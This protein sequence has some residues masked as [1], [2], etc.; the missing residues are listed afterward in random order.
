MAFRSG[1]VAVPPGTV[2]DLT[3]SY[4]RIRFPGVATRGVRGNFASVLPPGATIALLCT[5]PLAWAAEL[6]G[7]GQACR[8]RSWFTPPASMPVRSSPWRELGKDEVEQVLA[9]A[10][11]LSSRERVVAMSARFLGTPYRVSPLGEGAGKDPDPRFRLDAVD[12][13]TFVE[14]TLALSV[15]RQ[16]SQ[17]ER[18]LE[19]IRYADEVSYGGRNHL[20]E[21][22]W[23]PNNSRKGLIVDVTRQYGG[24]S[25]IRVEKKILPTTWLAPSARALDLPKDKQITGVFP[26]DVIPLDAVRDIAAQIPSGTIL[27]VV[28][29]ERPW[30]VT[31]ISHVGFIVQLDGKTFVRHATAGSRARV[32]DEPLP[33]FLAR[34]E[35]IE[36]RAVVGVSLFEPR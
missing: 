10:A 30:L 6:H 8:V 15:A 2:K 34:N 4:G 36:R 11:T 22:Q 35:K 17:V 28:R 19:E 25:T 9:D 27:V 18:A 32:L 20:M 3:R 26:M 12:C 1:Q 13:L 23:L 16:A 29:E 31:R 33:T 24:A 14:E 7:E 21:A 5:A